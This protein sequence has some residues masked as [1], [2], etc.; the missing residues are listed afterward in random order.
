MYDFTSRA[1][2]QAC[3]TDE[4]ELGSLS[5]LLKSIANVAA[6]NVKQEETW[7]ESSTCKMPPQNEDVSVSYS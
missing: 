2:V 4:Q 6:R 5:L 7:A 1:E 3:K